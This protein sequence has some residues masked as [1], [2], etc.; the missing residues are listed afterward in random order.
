MNRIG[1]PKEI[2]YPVY[3]TAGGLHMPFMPIV[4]GE[5]NDH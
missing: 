1:K 4:S 3:Y 2:G 5:D